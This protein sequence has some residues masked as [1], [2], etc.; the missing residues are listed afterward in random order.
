LPGINLPFLKSLTA[1]LETLG[2][3]DQ[4]GAQLLSLGSN[5]TYNNVYQEPVFFCS[6]FDTSHL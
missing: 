3:E 4:A 2:I 6:L 5:Y 1:N